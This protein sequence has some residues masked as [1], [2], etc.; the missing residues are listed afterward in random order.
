MTSFFMTNYTKINFYL[1]EIEK[2]INDGT[3][4]NLIGDI[5]FPSL[6][7]DNVV[8]KDIFNSSLVA[9]YSYLVNKSFEILP[10]LSVD[11]RKVMRILLRIAKEKRDC[12]YIMLLLSFFRHIQKPK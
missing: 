10:K 1:T 2:C 3:I 5:T 4:T 11:E 7:V 8:K 12:E 6:I 9:K